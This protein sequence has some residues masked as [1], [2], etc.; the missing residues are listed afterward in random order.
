MSVKQRLAKQILMYMMTLG[1]SLEFDGFLEKF[2][3]LVWLETPTNIFS[4]LLVGLGT[5]CINDYGSS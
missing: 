5:D 3:Q 2:N 4:F 1:E